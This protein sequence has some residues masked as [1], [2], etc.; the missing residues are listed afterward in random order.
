MLHSFAPQSMLLNQ[1]QSRAQT[2]KYYESAQVH[3]SHYEYKLLYFLL[4]QLGILQL[5][6]LNTRIGL[7]TAHFRMSRILTQIMAVSYTHLTLPTN[8]EV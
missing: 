7:V 3:T 8:R 1:I 4:K 2:T 5:C 6:Y